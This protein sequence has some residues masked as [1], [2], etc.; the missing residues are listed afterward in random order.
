[1]NDS[2][3][4][5]L[6]HK[7]EILLKADL[8]RE[9]N[10]PKITNKQI[11]NFCSNDY[12]G[13]SKEK[14]LI[15]AAYQSAL[16]FGIGAG[17]SRLISGNTKLHSDLEIEIANFKGTENALL[18]NSG[19][20]ANISTIAALMS[21]PDIIYSDELNHSSILSGIKLSGAN[22]LNYNHLCLKSLEEKIK[23][24][25]FQYRNALIISESIFSMDGDMA[26]LKALISVAEKYNCWLMIDEAHS[27]GLFGENGAGLIKSLKLENRIPIQMGTCS[28]AFGCQGAYIAG[29]NL[30]IEFLIQRAKTFIYST[31][32]SPAICGALKQSLKLIS[33]EKW[34]REKLFE[35]ADKIK[36]ICKNLD[37]KIIS[38]DSQIICLEMPNNKIALKA[39]EFLLKQG[40]LIQAIRP[41]TVKKARLRITAST[42]YT[43][44][45]INHL[46]SNLTDLQ[47]ALSGW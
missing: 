40:I 8:K 12:L 4:K 11:I 15:E 31:A 37:Y 46:V 33:T 17:A 36:T 10:L 25:R 1:M 47:M 9:L 41:P 20:D 30:L 35:N 42:I 19:Y 24:T 13:L 32:L 38:Q 3:N 44:A 27:T 23:S 26:D 7:L 45:Q 21:K 29:N 5:F 22:C 16:E 6:S 39:A 18:F 34:R 14:S 2:L 28:K 43:K